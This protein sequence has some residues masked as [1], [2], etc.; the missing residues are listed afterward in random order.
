MTPASHTT[1]NTNIMARIRSIRSMVSR[2]SD[3]CNTDFPNSRNRLSQ[4]KRHIESIMVSSHPQ[5]NTKVHGMNRQSHHSFSEC[6][7]SRVLGGV[8]LSNLHTCSGSEPA[9]FKTS[10]LPYRG[11][12]AF[13]H[14]SLRS[15]ASM[16]F[17]KSCSPMVVK[18]TPT[19]RVGDA[20]EFACESPNRD[21]RNLALKEM[22][23]FPY[24]YA[25]ALSPAWMF[26]RKT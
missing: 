22:L 8:K 15:A 20:Q 2:T 26:G 25:S 24:N 10:V 1:N 21:S 13:Q 9:T 6:K 11:H 23:H 3:K 14:L 16:I 17:G 5:A 7:S 19:S 18:Q 12:F 4:R